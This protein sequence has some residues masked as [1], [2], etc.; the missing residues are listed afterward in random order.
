MAC[1]ELPTYYEGGSTRVLLIGSRQYTVNGATVQQIRVSRV[2]G[3]HM[4]AAGI[5]RCMHMHA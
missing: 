4:C 3:Q 1:R 2:S 5:R